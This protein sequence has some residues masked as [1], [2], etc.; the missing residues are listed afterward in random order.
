MGR[1]RCAPVDA[2]LRREWRDLLYSGADVPPLLSAL[3]ER[4]LWE[5]I[6]ED[7]PDGR[8]LLRVDAAAEVAAEAWALAQ[9][10]RLPLESAQFET[11]DD[12]AAFRRWAREF[13]TL[14]HRLGVLDT[15]RLP[16]LL[17]R[18]P[19]TSQREVVLHGFDELDPRQ[20]ALAD[21]YRMTTIPLEERR[22]G[23]AALAVLPDAD[24]EIEAAALWARRILESQPG[25]RIGIAVPRLERLRGSIERVLQ[26]TLHPGGAAVPAFHV[27]LGPALSERP[28]VHA[29]LLLLDT[30]K[31]LVPI[32][33]LGRILLSP[34]IGQAAP[35]RS[36]R[37]RFDAQLRRDA[38]EY[39]LA[40]VAANTKCPPTFAELLRAVEQVRAAFPAKQPPSAWSRAFSLL[41]HAYGWPGDRVLS[42]AEFQT[43]EAF[44]DVLSELASL[45]AV[46][47]AVT[48]QAALALVRRIAGETQFQPEDLGQPVQVVGLIEASQETFDHLWVLGLDDETW[49]RAA[50]PNP[51]LPLS[52]QREHGLPHATAQW[53]LEWSRRVTARLLSA[54]PH[55]SSVTRT[56]RE[57]GRWLPVRWSRTCRPR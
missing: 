43:V 49:P 53:E 36:A 34:W 29:A 37:A 12:A 23:S 11:S 15:A 13:D 31:P 7:S 18:M 5:R 19:R 22:A 24:S 25:A 46:S 30:V 3:Q 8:E 14:C 55:V 16:D 2:W 6:I 35:E 20:K 10:W 17:A 32:A 1:A 9:A 48:A 44:R 28:A 47:P 40:A 42:S 38:S 39:T 4:L 41:L 27:S 56:L 26:A 21:A 54:A 51:F 33:P 52:L 45:D 50:S 57:N